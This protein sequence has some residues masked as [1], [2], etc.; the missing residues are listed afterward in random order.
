MGRAAFDLLHLH[1]VLDRLHTADTAR[2]A[3]GR[4]DI[5]ARA[6]EAAQLNDALERLDVDLGDFQARLTE[7]GGLHLGRDRTVINVLAGAFMR[8]CGRTAKRGHQYEGGEERDERFDWIHTMRLQERSRASVCT[9]GR[10][11]RCASALTRALSE[12]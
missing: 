8:A 3:N 9:N 12:P 11:S 4:I 5:V 10:E 1:I 7:D 6:H 2:H